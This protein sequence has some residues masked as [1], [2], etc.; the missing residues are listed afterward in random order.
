MEN[1][2]K[3]II[4]TLYKLREAFQSAE[5]VMYDD[6]TDE[7]LV[8]FINDIAKDTE[9][10]KIKGWTILT[11]MLGGFDLVWKEISLRTKEVLPILFDNKN[12]LINL[13]YKIK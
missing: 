5:K 1:C 3:E 11:E 2:K 12:K 10:V 7:F 9:Y 13:L 8:D 6:N 4:E